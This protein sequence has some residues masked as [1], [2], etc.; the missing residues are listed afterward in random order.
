MNNMLCEENSNRQKIK[1]T[2][3]DVIVTGTFEKP[4]YE[5]KWHEVGHKDYCIGYSSYNLQFVFTWLKEN[6]IIVEDYPKEGILRKLFCRHKL[7]EVVCWHWTH[8]RIGNN[9]R[10]L[11]IQV[12][13]KKCGKLHF[14]YIYDWNKCEAF[15]KCHKDTEWSDKCKPIL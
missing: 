7:N 14:K 9:I 11:Q 4:C 3:A 2:S 5:I 13:C 8:G 6:F 10:F 1:V 12:R 15:I